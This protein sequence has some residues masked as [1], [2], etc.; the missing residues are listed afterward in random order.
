MEQIGR[1]LVPVICT[2]EIADTSRKTAVPKKN[3][4]NSNFVLDFYKP[5]TYLCTVTKGEHYEEH[6]ERS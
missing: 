4:T 3:F 1:V 2:V 5:D 6:S